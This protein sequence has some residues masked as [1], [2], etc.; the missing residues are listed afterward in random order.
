MADSITGRSGAGLPM[1]HTYGYQILLQKQ[2][3]DHDTTVPSESTWTP[4]ESNDQYTIAR[5]TEAYLNFFQI[6]T[7]VF[8]T[9]TPGPYG[10]LQEQFRSLRLKVIWTKNGGLAYSEER[11]S[12]LHWLQ[13]LAN[14]KS[15]LT[16]CPVFLV[17]DNFERLYVLLPCTMN[18]DYPCGS[19]AVRKK[20]PKQYAVLARLMNLVPSSKQE[21]NLYVYNM[22]KALRLRSDD[23]TELIPTDDAARVMAPYLTDEDTSSIIR[24]AL[25]GLEPD[26][27]VI[28]WCN[29]LTDYDIELTTSQWYFDTKV[30]VEKMW[31]TQSTP[32]IDASTFLPE[33]DMLNLLS[34]KKGKALYE[35]WVASAKES[36]HNG[37][38]VRAG[39]YGIENGDLT[40][41]ETFIPVWLEQLITKADVY[42]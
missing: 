27:I 19:F 41:R 29:L 34:I 6:G 16:Q 22:L 20:I 33:Y 12:I 23:S 42:Y 2:Q 5:D 10:D 14:T 35:D 32:K 7:R 3:Y 9:V 36:D 38:L 8:F 21:N 4:F 18:K 25:L 13:R 28:R 30:I 31:K 26:S 1:S 40:G 39:K 15:I 17:C 24:G 11:T 37:A